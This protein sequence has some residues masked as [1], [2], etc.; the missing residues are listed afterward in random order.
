M[1]H[2]TDFKTR[3]KSLSMQPWGYG[4]SNLDSLTLNQSFTS[5]ERR[6]SVALPKHKKYDK[7]GSSGYYSDESVVSPH[8]KIKIRPF[9]TYSPDE[10]D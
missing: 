8:E 2:G 9:E 6:K 1:F 4:S 3:I 5:E 7:S 10:S